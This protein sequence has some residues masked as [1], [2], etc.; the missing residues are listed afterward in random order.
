[1][2]D[3]INNETIQAE[4]SIISWKQFLH[5]AVHSSVQFKTACLSSQHQNAPQSL[6]HQ[7]FRESYEPFESAP[8]TDRVLLSETLLYGHIGEK[9]TKLLGNARVDLGAEGHIQQLQPRT[10]LQ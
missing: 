5:V 10:G 8:A 4:T 2:C 1:M 9:A 6:T 3:S 7:C